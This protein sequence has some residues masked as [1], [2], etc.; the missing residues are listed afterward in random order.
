MNCTATANLTP[1]ASL[2]EPELFV[3]IGSIQP[4]HYSIGKKK[5]HHSH[6]TTVSL[7]VSVSNLSPTNCVPF[8]RSGE[9][10]RIARSSLTLSSILK[11]SYQLDRQQEEEE[12][13]EIQHLRSSNLT[14][15]HLGQPFLLSRCNLR[16]GLADRFVVEMRH[17]AVFASCQKRCTNPG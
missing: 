4:R 2:K 17:A 14:K 12:N 1:P 11:Q 15:V 9:F 10:F 5:S 3:T 6:S 13:D 8:L 16:Q 7:P